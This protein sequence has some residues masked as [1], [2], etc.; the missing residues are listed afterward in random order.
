MPIYGV[1]T[2]IRL[3]LRSYFNLD[4]NLGTQKTKVYKLLLQF[5]S[6]KCSALSEQDM[7][8]Y[9]KKGLKSYNSLLCLYCMNP[10]IFLKEELRLEIA[11]TKI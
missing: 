3:S 4:S 2:Y 6:R 8:V 9:L 5:F 7:F 11:L 1:R 10:Q